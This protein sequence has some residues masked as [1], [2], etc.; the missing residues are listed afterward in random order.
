MWPVGAPWVKNSQVSL[1]YSPTEWAPTVVTP[2]KWPY[3][4]GN[5]GEK[6]LLIAQ[7]EITN[8]NRR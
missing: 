4:M 8:F 3:K 1:G 5:W 7:E 2:T 6:T